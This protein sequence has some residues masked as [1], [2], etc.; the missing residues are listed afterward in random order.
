MH[1]A[2]SLREAPTRET[3]HPGQQPTGDAPAPSHQPN[4][5]QE[6]HVS[7]S[8]GG[9]APARKD[10]TSSTATSATT[11]SLA[12]LASSDSTAT[13]YTVEQSPTVATQGVFPVREGI[14]VAT[15]RKASR[16]RTGPLSSEQRKRAALIRKLGACADC[17]RR[18]VAVSTQPV[19]KSLTQ[20]LHTWDSSVPPQSP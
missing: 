2:P 3:P 11:A 7:Q 17:R 4:G 20:S 18:R 6:N 1:P 5:I 14:D 15:Q 8:E 13:G 12:T 10:T 16:R 9:S 19:P